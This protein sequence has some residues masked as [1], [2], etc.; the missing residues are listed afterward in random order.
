MAPDFVE[1]V[2][3]RAARTRRGIRSAALRRITAMS[4]RKRL[5]AIGGAL[6]TLLLAFVGGYTGITRVPWDRRPAA[7]AP[8]HDAAA[9]TLPLVAPKQPPR[10]IPSSAPPDAPTS[11]LPCEETPR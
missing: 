11:P 9:S 5:R 2:V 3:A 6:L 1:T 7:S 4:G 10:P 8:A